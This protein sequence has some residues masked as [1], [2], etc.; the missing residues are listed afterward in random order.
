MTKNI[1]KIQKIKKGVKIVNQTPVT[2]MRHGGLSSVNQKKG[3]RNNGTDKE[4][5]HTPPCR[6]GI[7][8][9]VMGYYESFLVSGV[10]SKNKCNKE[11]KIQRYRKF[12]YTGDLWHHLGDYCE[13]GDILDTK[14][15][16]S[17][18]SYKVFCGALQKSLHRESIRT[19]MWFKQEMNRMQ[20]D[21]KPQNW[22]SY[23]NWVSNDH[24]E[25]FIE[26]V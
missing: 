2:F 1:E 19:A 21:F 6:R 11:G 25:V 23:K 3:Y 4:T 15:S 18:T 24:L 5:F 7:Y 12:I 14:G 17:K 10:C 16:W 26:K 9:F 22:K 8:A 20:K 13:K